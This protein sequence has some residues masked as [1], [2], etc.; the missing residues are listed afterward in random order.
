MNETKGTYEIDLHRLLTV[1][2]K[3]WWVM[4]LPA[5]LCGALLFIHSTFYTT[6]VY[7]TTAKMYIRA[8]STSAIDGSS[9]STARNLVATYSYLIKETRLTLDEVAK[10]ANL[11]DKYNY[12]QLRSMISVSDGNDTEFLEIT[13]T[14]ADAEDAALIANTITQVLP[15]RAA[16]TQL[17]SEV[18]L[19][20]QAIVPEAPVAS[21]ANRNVII[22]FFL[23]FIIGAAMIVLQEVLNDK[24]PSEDWLKQT[25]HDEIPLLA[26]IPSSDPSDRKYGRYASYYQQY[27]SKE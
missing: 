3:K 5:L 6:P 13:V 23:G 14:S 15:A 12:A 2:L 8:T 27:S 9:L 25:F 18:V 24:I 10:K 26:V 11:E 4:I 21:N 20:D 7:R 19:V 17:T 22:G 16:A 1:M